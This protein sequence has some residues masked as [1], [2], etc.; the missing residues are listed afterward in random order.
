MVANAGLIRFLLSRATPRDALLICALAAIGFG[1]VVMSSY[2]A[3]R[4]EAARYTF[5]QEC[6]MDRKRYECAVLWSAANS[7]IICARL[8]PGRCSCSRRKGAGQKR[9]G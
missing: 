7:R 1:A 8:I 6:V 9:R 4:R 3:Q 2:N 5:M